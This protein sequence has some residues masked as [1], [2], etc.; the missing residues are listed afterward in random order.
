MSDDIIMNAFMNNP[1]QG[2][3]LFIIEGHPERNDLR[4]I[5]ADEAF[6]DNL[7]C[8]T[9][10]IDIGYIFLGIF[11]EERLAQHYLAA[12]RDDRDK[13]TLFQSESLFVVE[14]NPGE[15]ELK[16]TIAAQAFTANL[17][18]F[19]LGISTGY[20]YMGIF[21]QEQSAREYIALIRKCLR[22][23]QG[24]RLI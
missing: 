23:D 20:Q 18:H 1:I 3:G 5:P 9:W 13:D 4:I 14:G 15:N 16:I 11:T 12:I 24:T 7:N 2:E 21:T 8:F 6:K 17:V 19:E 22:D 10:N